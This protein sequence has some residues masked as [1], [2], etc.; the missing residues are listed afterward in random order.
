MD[1]I[2]CI[3]W[4]HALPV[5]SLTKPRSLVHCCL[6]SPDRTKPLLN[7]GALNNAFIFNQDNAV[8]NQ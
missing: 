5:I 8:K 4:D 1:P 6:K 7:T 2:T 3:Q